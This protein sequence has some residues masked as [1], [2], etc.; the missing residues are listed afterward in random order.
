MV[1]YSIEEIIQNEKVRKKLFPCE[2]PNYPK[3]LSQ[4]FELF[5]DALISARKSPN[6][7][8][9]YYF[10]LKIFLDYVVSYHPEIKSVDEI[11]LFTIK[12]FYKYLEIEKSNSYRSITRKKMV[13][14]MF[15]EYL[16]EQGILDKNKNPIPVEGIIKGNY[17][18]SK[19]LPV[20]LEINEIVQLFELIKMDGCSDFMKKRNLSIVSLL[21]NSG[22][23]ISELVSL[24]IQD[25]NI[26]FN[27][28]IL[29]ITGK[30]NKQRIVPINKDELTKGSLV[31]L[32][33]YYEMR[34][35]M[36]LADEG[37]FLSNK[38][39]RITSRGVQLLMK[40]YINQMDIDK[41]VTPHKLRH[42]YATHLIKNN[43]NLR[44]VQELL[45]HSSISTTQIYTHVNVEDLREEVSGLK[46]GV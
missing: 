40:K 26:L 24:N 46:Y 4:L 20:Y 16:I 5:I 6:T 42:T 7:I 27:Q 19:K 37:L 15:V 9:S 39:R 11:E 36:D 33:E 29:V 30:G 35:E 10:D 34:K 21:I 32:R 43:A 2:A 22:L 31:Y 14:K 23:R 1:N 28:N 18:K 25:M 3:N 44:R 41:V 12:K 8:A 13:L 17:T 45:G 38:N